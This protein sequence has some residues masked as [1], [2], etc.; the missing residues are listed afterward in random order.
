MATIK[1]DENGRN[2]LGAVTNDVNQDIRNLLVNPITGALLVEADILST[3]TDIGS[4]ILGGTQGSVLFLGLGSTLA[5]DNANFF[6]DDLNV[7]FPSSFNKRSNAAVK[8]MRK[9]TRWIRLIR[10]GISQSRCIM[11]MMVFFSPEAKLISS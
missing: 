7:G 8:P 10:M 6:W 2:I 4:T 5:E 9:S 3:N 1:I 11:G